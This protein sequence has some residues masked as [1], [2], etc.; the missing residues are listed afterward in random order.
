M[1]LGRTL[2]RVSKSRLKSLNFYELKQHKLWF[3]EVCLGS[4]DQSQHSKMQWLHDPNQS[5]V[6]DINNVRREAKNK[7]E[8]LK[9]AI[10][11]IETNI[12]IK[13]LDSFTGT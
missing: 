1:G 10:D 12:K 9:D 5:N 6:D 7:K 2:K 8:Y 11:E 3:D 13:K 4:L